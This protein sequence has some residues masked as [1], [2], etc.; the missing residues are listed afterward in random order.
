MD[1]FNLRYSRLSKLVLVP[2]IIL[3]LLILQIASSDLDSD[4]QSLIAFANSVPHVRELNWNASSSVCSWFGVTCASDSSRVIALRLPGTGL[5]GPIPANT[6]GKLD[7]LRT[8]SLR[9]NFLSEN[10]PA[11]ISN[12]TF[13]E[14]LSVQ[15]NNLSGNLPIS[16]PSSLIVVDLSFNSLSGQ[17][18]DLNLPKLKRFNISNN[19]LNGSIPNS[20]QKFP[21]TSFAGNSLLCGTPLPPCSRFFLSPSSP[22]L[23]SSPTPSTRSSTNNLSTGVIIAIAAGILTVLMLLALFV[24]VCMLRKKS[25]QSNGVR[26]AKE[27][28]SNGGRIEKAV[29]KS[30]S[31]AREAE[32]NKLVFF[33]GCSYNFDL[34]DLLRASAEVLGKGSYGTAYKAVLEDGTL[35]VVKRIKDVTIGKREFEQQM[36][37]IGNIRKHP[38]VLPLRAYY[39]SKDEKLLVFDHVPTGSL[40][41]HLHGNMIF[42]FLSCIKDLM[43]SD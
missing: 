14:N 22:P 31:G 17:I 37:I 36:E 15:N 29:E 33:E 41:F 42:F 6:L 32:K 20:L 2:L 34:E 30:S 4:R 16:L 7:A 39:H 35:V 12:M 19:N 40:G 43:C 21:N 28:S 5:Y 1:Q 23:E 26:R 24:L 8:L 27:K 9:S 3:P 11:D 18:P 38:N 25:N 13:L 10:I